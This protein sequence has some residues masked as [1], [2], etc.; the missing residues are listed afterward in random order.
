M[1]TIV[2]ST[3]VV[4]SEP[5]VDVLEILPAR[6]FKLLAC[7][8][9]PRR[10]PRAPSQGGDDRRHVK[11]GWTSSTSSSATSKGTA[12]APDTSAQDSLAI[13][14]AWD[15][16]TFRVARAVLKH[17]FTDQL[18]FVFDALSAKQGR[19]SILSVGTFLRVSTSSRPARVAEVGPRAGQGRV[20]GARQVRRHQ[21]ATRR[22]PAAHRHSRGAGH[23][24]G[25]G[26]PAQRGRSARRR[27]SRSTPGSTSGARSRAPASSGA[28]SSSRSAR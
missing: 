7:V 9:T 14:D 12:P 5:S 21:G 4:V 15:E 16:P 24:G 11:E 25:A 6:T 20:G 27:S 28:I 23:A 2:N 8:G 18:A 17:G 10:P 26:H 1:N 19:E 13:V 22:D 3:V